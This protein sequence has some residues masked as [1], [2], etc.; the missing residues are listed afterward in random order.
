MIDTK[1]PRVTSTQISSKT[2][3][4]T[5]GFSDESSGVSSGSLTNASAYHLSILGKGGQL[6]PLTITSMKTNPSSSGQMVLPSGQIVVAFSTG[7]MKIKAKSAFQ[8]TITGG[9]VTDVA[10]NAL[11]GAFNGTFPSGN[12]T[13][14]SDFV[15]T[16]SPTAVGPNHHHGKH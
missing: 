13:N 2:H 15:Q 16:L 12:G 5:V 3:T 11:D 6:T 1:G 4:L 9:G 10:G 8:V 14:G 7:T